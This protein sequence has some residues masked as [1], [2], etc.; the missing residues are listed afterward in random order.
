MADEG[1]DVDGIGGVSLGIPEQ[2]AKDQWGF[3]QLKMMFEEHRVLVDPQMNDSEKI[4]AL[5]K[6]AIHRLYLHP[7][8]RHRKDGKPLVDPRD[9]ILKDYEAAVDEINKD[10]SLNNEEKV[11]K[12]FMAIN[13]KIVR[14]ISDLDDR[15]L[16]FIRTLRV[17]RGGDAFWENE[18]YTQEQEEEDAEAWL[19]PRKTLR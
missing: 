8:P 13:Q 11:D 3:V 2:K 4:K 18:E 10:R 17:S 5:E 1:K 14:P 15:W 16:G 7:G 19:D 9:E 12:I 6:S